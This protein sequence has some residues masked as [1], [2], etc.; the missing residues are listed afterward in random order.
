[1]SLYSQLVTFGLVAFHWVSLYIEILMDLTKKTAYGILDA[2]RPSTWLFA[3]R[4]TVPW[5]KKMSGEVKNSSYP[6]VY[7]PETNSF[8]LN[9]RGAKGTKGTKGANGANG[10]KGVFGDVVTVELV[11]SD[12]IISFDMSSFF[13]EVSWSGDADLAP[14]LYEIVLLF[15]LTNDIL[16]TVESMKGFS[17]E[18]LT[19]DSK[20]Y[21]VLLNSPAAL[22]NFKSWTIFGEV[23][24]EED[25]TP[26]A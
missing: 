24:S 4:N 6:M 23:P 15:L 20:E 14:S 22:E 9:A 5:I 10:V 18:V 13:H 26:V 21:T 19:A 12:R 1:M 7:S 8:I 11:N 25:E 17:L 3:E 2:H 16:F